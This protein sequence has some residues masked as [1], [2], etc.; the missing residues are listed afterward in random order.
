MEGSNN[1]CRA[2][3]SEGCKEERKRRPEPR[4]FGTAAYVQVEAASR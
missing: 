1:V 4:G 2:V 3:E